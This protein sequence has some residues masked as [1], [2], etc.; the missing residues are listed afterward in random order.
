MLTENFTNWL[1]LNNNAD[2]AAKSGIPYITL[3]VAKQK[4]S[5]KLQVVEKI[6]ESMKVHPIDVLFT[7][8][9]IKEYFDA[10]ATLSDHTSAIP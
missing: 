5:Y 10:S 8:E 1:K 7:K 4:K 3:I 6:C 9:E 2:I